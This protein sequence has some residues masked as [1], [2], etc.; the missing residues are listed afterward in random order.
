M[1]TFVLVKRYCKFLR[2]LFPVSPEISVVGAHCTDYGTVF[3]VH[4]VYISS[5]EK[6]K[7]LYGKI[8]AIV[9]NFCIQQS[10]RN[11]VFL[12]LETAYFLL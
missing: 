3:A 4:H 6:R 11:P 8:M 9:L 7:L 5:L 2:T 12:S 10:V 1:Y